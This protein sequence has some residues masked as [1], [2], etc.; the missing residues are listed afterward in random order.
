MKKIDQND[1][2]KTE[3]E[4]EALS[5]HEIEIEE[6]LNGEEDYKNEFGEEDDEEDSGKGKFFHIAFLILVLL[7]ICAI[8]FMIWRWQKGVDLVVT[9]DDLTEN[10][11]IESMDYYSH[12]DPSEQEGYVDDGEMNIVFMGDD[13]MYYCDDETSIPSLVAE[14]TGAKV[15]TLALPGQTLSNTEKGYTL[16]HPEDAYN[17]Y[18]VAMA[19]SAGDNGQYDLMTAAW[20][21][22]NELGFS[23][24]QFG[25]YYDY[26]NIAHSIDFDEVD[27][28][29][30]NMGVNDFLK[31]RPLMGDEIRD[32]QM[33]GLG[34][35]TNASMH[36]ALTTLKTRY[37]YMQIIVASP[38]FILTDDGNGN[39]VGADKVN[40]GVGYYGDYIANMSALCQADCVTF[41]D[42]YLDDEFNP[43][44]YEGKLEDNGIYPSAEGRKIMADNIISNLYFIRNK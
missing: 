42:N 2:T 31:E 29:V 33:Y 24:E 19:I 17:L 34:N 41:V 7:I 3:A 27:V 38:N 11:D 40:N 44:N 30:I 1:L 10:Y 18:Y 14:A 4:N 21:Y 35:G 15:R 6:K 20:E 8:V 43:D 12:F 9:E 16:D 32:G 25:W 36:E 23:E 13:A 37:P 26:W 39:L 28:L 22:M 5:G